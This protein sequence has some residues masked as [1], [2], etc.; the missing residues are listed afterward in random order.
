MWRDPPQ[1][2]P[3]PRKS[4]RVQSNRILP[5]PVKPIP[6]QWERERDGEGERGRE[7]GRER[8]KEREKENER[9]RN[10]EENGERKEIEKEREQAVVVFPTLC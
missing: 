10:R 8:A 2:S 4:D 6:P 3:R 9:E 7:G 1:L 5:P